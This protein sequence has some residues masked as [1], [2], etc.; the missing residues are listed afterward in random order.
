M[1]QSKTYELS[2]RDKVTG[3]TKV[4]NK[5]LP[6][7]MRMA[8]DGIAMQKSRDELTYY[9]EQVPAWQQTHETIKQ[10]AES[11]KALAMELLT[12]DEGT[13]IA[14]RQAYA[15][16]LTPEKELAR[17]RAQIQAGQVSQTVPAPAQQ[18]A[19]PQINPQVQQQ[20]AALAQRIGPAIQNAESVVGPEAA[21]GKLVRDLA[22]LMVNGVVPVERFAE[23]EAYVNGPYRE[24]VTAQGAAKQTASTQA[25]KEL[26]AAKAERQ[27]AQLSARTAGTATRPTGVL[28]NAAPAP[29][30]KPQARGV[31]DVINN[32]V[33]RPIAAA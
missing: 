21:A 8:K 1:D 29:V 25:A 16:E 30:S 5:T 22:P 32:I 27:R 11:F 13:V 31:N 33:R 9:R 23:V 6:D 15:A 2:I 17:L 19:Q 14:R 3:E 7:L 28:S 24:W 12:A 20:Q 18:P 4:Y 26:E 10:E